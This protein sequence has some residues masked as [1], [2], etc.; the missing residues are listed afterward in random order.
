MNLVDRPV[1]S[2]N[3]DSLWLDRI[4]ESVDSMSYGNIHIKIHDGK[5]VEIETS[6]KFRFSQSA[7]TYRPH[8]FPTTPVEDS[9]TSEKPVPAELTADR[10]KA[11]KP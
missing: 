7:A 3:I 9:H 8:H 4:R 5:V 2:G 10:T 6:R 11:T 1:I